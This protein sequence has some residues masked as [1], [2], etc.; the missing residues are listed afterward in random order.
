MIE[1]LVDKIVTQNGATFGIS[2][3]DTTIKSNLSLI[4]D[5]LDLYIFNATIKNNQK[6]GF[7]TF[8]TFQQFIVYI[9]YEPI[10]GISIQ[11]I[12]FNN[13]DDIALDEYLILKEKKWIQSDREKIMQ[14]YS[15]IKETN[16]NFSKLVELPHYL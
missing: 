12:D 11:F 9:N 5:E 2:T 6:E 14:L 1:I 8:E 15:E 13:E 16:N 3:K 4:F 7:H 10:L